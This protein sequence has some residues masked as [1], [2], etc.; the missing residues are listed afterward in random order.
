M[1]QRPQ[2]SSSRWQAV[3]VEVSRTRSINGNERCFTNERGGFAAIT[4][5]PLTVTGA[6]VSNKVYDGTTQATLTGG[7]I[8]AFGA[9][10]VTLTQ[11]AGV[12][13]DKNAGTGKSVTVSGYALTG[14][15]AGNYTLTQPTSLTA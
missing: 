5:A 12:F 3:C 8:T 13:A 2:I 6:T 1:F 11:G 14:A 15:D 10:V 7:T 4:A 9:D